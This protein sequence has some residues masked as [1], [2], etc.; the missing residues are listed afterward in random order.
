MPKSYG[1]SGYT[2]HKR[3]QYAKKARPVYKKAFV[4][5]P[6]SIAKRTDFRGPGG[7]AKYIDVPYSATYMNTTGVITHLDVVPRGTAV[8]EREGRC[9]RNTKV[10]FI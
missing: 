6:V 3:R 10:F 4:K 5:R 1:T 9:W 2:A 7:D 8:T